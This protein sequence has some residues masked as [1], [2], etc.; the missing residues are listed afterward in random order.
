LL[1]WQ[2]GKYVAAPQQLWLIP[3]EYT[4]RHRDRK[5]PDEFVARTVTV[6]HALQRLTLER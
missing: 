2:G 1:V 3:G 5:S 6:G 4:L